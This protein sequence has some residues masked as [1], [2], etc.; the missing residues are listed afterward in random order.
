MDKKQ[1]RQ[2]MRTQLCSYSSEQLAGKSQIACKNLADTPEFQKATTIMAFLSMPH[3]IDTAAFIMYAWQHTKTIAVPKI[4]W[5]QRHMIPVQISSLEAGIATEAGGLRNPVTGIPVPLE[6]IDLVVTPGLAFDKEG[7]RL[8]RG[9]SYYDRFF[10]HEKLRAIKCGFGFAEQI[11][12][13]VP[14]TEHDQ[15]VDMLVTDEGV[16]YIK[17]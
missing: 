17:K 2:Q 8:G 12:P 13:V 1:L 5:Q 7:N 11:I 6:D 15:P 3:E 16:I 4:S 9:G 14:T 10:P